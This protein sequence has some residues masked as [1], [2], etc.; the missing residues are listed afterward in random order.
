MNGARLPLHHTRSHF[1]FH[2]VPLIFFFLFSLIHLIFLLTKFF[3]FLL[4]HFLHFFLLRPQLSLS[5]LLSFPFPSLRSSS[6]HSFVFL[7]IFYS[8][9]FF[10]L[11]LN[12]LFLPSLA[13]FF[14]PF[15]LLL[16]IPSFS[17]I[18]STPSLPSLFSSSPSTFSFFP[19]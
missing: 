5:P 13:S 4:L 10:F 17:F 1:T 8:F 6:S 11:A 12:F 16:H 18:F 15:D 3:I 7:H 2:V 19:P 9:T 14:L